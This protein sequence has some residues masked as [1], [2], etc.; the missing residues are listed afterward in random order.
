[1]GMRVQDVLLQP[2]DDALSLH[3]RIGVHGG[4]AP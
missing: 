2:C 4:D 3:E 1:M